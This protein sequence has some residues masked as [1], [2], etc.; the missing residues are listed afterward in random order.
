MYLWVKRSA[1]DFLQTDN[2]K[3]VFTFIKVSSVYVTLDYK[4][5]VLAKIDC[6]GLNCIGKCIG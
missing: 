5:S 2:K 1:V 4:T 3:V 6:M